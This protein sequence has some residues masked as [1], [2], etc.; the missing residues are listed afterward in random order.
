MPLEK[1]NGAFVFF[2]GCAGFE[3]AKIPAPTRFW[4]FLSRIQP[5]LA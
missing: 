3:C 2:R 5:A 4:I 1:L